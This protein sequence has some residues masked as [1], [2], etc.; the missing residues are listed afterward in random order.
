M[1]FRG[2]CTRCKVQGAMYGT[3]GMKNPLEL[4]TWH[5]ALETWDQVSVNLAE[6]ILENRYD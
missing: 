2:P 1:K 6:Y 5:L 4:G 3:T